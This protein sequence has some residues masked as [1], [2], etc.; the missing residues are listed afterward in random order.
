[1][2]SRPFQPAASSVRNAS[3]AEADVVGR[4]G[5]LVL[6]LAVL[7][8]T[9]AQA[10]ELAQVMRSQRRLQ[11]GLAIELALEERPHHLIDGDKRQPAAFGDSA[12]QARDRA[13]KPHFRQH[14]HLGQLE[15]RPPQHG[16]EVLD[17]AG[18]VVAIDQGRAKRAE[19]ARPG[20]YDRDAER[21]GRAIDGER[22]Q[23]PQP[24]LVLVAVADDGE[25]DLAILEARHRRR[26][27]TRVE[28]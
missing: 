18:R 15:V 19:R 11:I 6:E 24:A 12:E 16:E 4:A 10:P 5:D 27:E 26:Q 21:N 8:K 28:E 17:D 3:S 25:P 20:A 2:R 1:M 7:G 13:I 23:Q 22:H 14:E 9:A